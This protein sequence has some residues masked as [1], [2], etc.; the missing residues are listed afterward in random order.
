MNKA[1]NDFKNVFAVIFFAIGVYFLIMG[2]NHIGIISMVSLFIIVFIN[3]D[4]FYSNFDIKH[5][6]TFSVAT[7]FALIFINSFV[8]FL[9]NF[10]LPSKK[11]LLF[12]YKN[13]NFF[14]SL[15]NIF[16]FK[17]FLLLFFVNV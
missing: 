16:T 9:L 1:V 2:V 14:H 12:F 7:V 11:F 13:K 5:Y 17:N 6:N 4:W 8:D 10:Y 15:P 3:S